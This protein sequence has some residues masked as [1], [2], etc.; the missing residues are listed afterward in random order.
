MKEFI[1]KNGFK[2]IWN[3]WDQSYK[4]YKNEKFLILSYRYSDVKNY[5]N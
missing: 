4:V 1:G 2:V 3:F 5:L